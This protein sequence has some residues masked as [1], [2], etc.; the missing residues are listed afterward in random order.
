MATENLRYIITVTEK[1]IIK[2]VISYILYYAHNNGDYI[3]NTT[4]RVKWKYIRIEGLN[5]LWCRSIHFSEH[6]QSPNFQEVY[7]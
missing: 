4:F 1:A 3:Q 6:N 2:W 5:F 7:K